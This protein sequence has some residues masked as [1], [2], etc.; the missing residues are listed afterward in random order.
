MKEYRIVIQ[1]EHFGAALPE[2]VT[3]MLANL[4]PAQFEM[5]LHGEAVKALVGETPLPAEGEIIACQRALNSQHITLD[6][7]P[8][9]VR[10]VPSGIAHI[11]RRQ[12]EGWA[13]LKL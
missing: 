7:L 9:N 6:Q 12:M 11:V 1:V 13:Y 3:N 10:L 5:V 2:R 4:G 8:T